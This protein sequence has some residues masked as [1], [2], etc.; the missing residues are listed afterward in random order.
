MQGVYQMVDRRHKSDLGRSER[1][2][3]RVVDRQLEHSTSVRSLRR[4]CSD[5][6]SVEASVTCSVVIDGGYMSWT[7]REF[8]RARYH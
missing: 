5:K 6:Q 2:L 4:A 1:V 7:S 8:M 3:F